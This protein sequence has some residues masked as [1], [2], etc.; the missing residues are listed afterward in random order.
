MFHIYKVAVIKGL[1]LELGK[2]YTIKWILS[3]NINERFDCHPS[4]NATKEKCQQLGCSWQV[5]HYFSKLIRQKKK[6]SRLKG[7][8]LW[9]LQN[10]SGLGD[11]SGLNKMGFSW[12]VLM[13]LIYLSS[14]QPFKFY[15][16]VSGVEE[17]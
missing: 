2:S 7:F 10:K 6:K 12:T 13:D 9:L 5:S 14:W 17:K 15:H 11:L 1:Q 16:I 3:M 8:P 4:P